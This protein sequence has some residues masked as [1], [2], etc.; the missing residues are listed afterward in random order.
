M[1]EKNYFSGDGCVISDMHLVSNF[2]V[3]FVIDL[4]LSI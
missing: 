3:F 4:V 2:S 1:C